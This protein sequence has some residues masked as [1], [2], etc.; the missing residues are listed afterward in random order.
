[1]RK[2]N[3]NRIIWLCAAAMTASLAAGCGQGAEETAREAEVLQGSTENLAPDARGPREDM[4]I[5]CVTEIA[6]QTITAEE[7]TFERPSPIDIP[8]SGNGG[9]GKGGADGG[10]GA[11]GEGGRPGADG[12]P[13]ADGEG[14]RPGRGGGL[15]RKSVV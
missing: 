3:R 12:G 2:R 1:M 10:P 7:G 11:D 14:G 9:P 5:F 8:D 6:E 15:D 13:G 4:R